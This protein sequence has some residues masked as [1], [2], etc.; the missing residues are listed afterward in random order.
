MFKDH[1]ENVVEGL[2]TERPCKFDL[3]REPVVKTIKKSY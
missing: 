1:F 2:H 3:D